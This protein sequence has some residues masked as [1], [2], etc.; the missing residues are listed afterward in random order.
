MDLI[1]YAMWDLRVR[2]LL[3][4]S[5]EFLALEAHLPTRTY[6]EHRFEEHVSATKKTR[7]TCHPG[8]FSLDRAVEPL[9]KT[10]GRVRIVTLQTAASRNQG[11]RGSDDHRK[12]EATAPA[13]H[14]QP[15][16]ANVRTIAGEYVYG[17]LE[18]ACGNI[19]ESEAIL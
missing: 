4:V 12:P 2:P 18:V 13:L 19:R 10:Y 15:R 11:E 3:R 7:V 1:C 16:D 9:L 6:V 14:L 17:S 8:W 5:S